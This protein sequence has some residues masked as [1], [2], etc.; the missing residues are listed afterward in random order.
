MSPK[1]LPGIDFLGQW[2]RYEEDLGGLAWRKSPS[3]RVQAGERA[4]YL[5]PEGYIRIAV[6]EF[7]FLEHRAVWL[8]TE[9]EDPGA[10]T[11]DHINRKRA[12]NRR[13]NLRLADPSQQTSNQGPRCDNTSGHRGVSRR[14]AGWEAYLTIRGKRQYL[15]TF[16]RIEDAIAARAAAEARLGLKVS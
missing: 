1:P 5:N 3:R 6:G 13:T 15:G 14:R 8:L 9:G 7:R 16:A 2:F 11:V 10:A 4:G 12:D